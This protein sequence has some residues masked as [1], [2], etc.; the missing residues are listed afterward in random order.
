MRQD[1]EAL[2]QRSRNSHMDS[3]VVEQSH[4]QRGG[5]VAQRGAQEPRTR[6]SGAW[7]L[8]GEVW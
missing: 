5:I 8:H 1:V 3:E 7:G 6:A 2:Q 4:G